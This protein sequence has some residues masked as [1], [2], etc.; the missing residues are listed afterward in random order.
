VVTLA[1]V[2]ATLQLGTPQE[3][4]GRVMSI[5]SVATNGLAPVGSLVAG[6]LAAFTSAPIAVASM[7]GI[8][9]VAVGALWLASRGDSAGATD[10][11]AA[12][13]AHTQ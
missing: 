4:R 3:M 8:G 1:T 6:S 7:A 2:N 9:A 11:L 10:P 5:L 12:A 13:A